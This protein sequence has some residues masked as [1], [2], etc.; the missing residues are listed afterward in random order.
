MGL[1]GMHPWV[2]WELADVI[3]RPLCVAFEVHGDWKRFVRAGRE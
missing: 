1:D 2:L 3:A